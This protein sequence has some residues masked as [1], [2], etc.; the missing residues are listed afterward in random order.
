MPQHTLIIGGAKS[1]KSALALELARKQGGR[2]VF[3][4]TAQAHDQEMARR[5]ARH[6]AERGPEWTTREEPL[7]LE[8]A[9]RE[10]DAPGAV[11]LVD[12]LTL[13]LSNLLTGAGL[14]PEQVAQRGRGLARL[15]PGL[16]ARVILVGNE[17]GLGIV[18]QHPLARSFRDLSGGLHQELARICQR[19]VLCAAG[20]PLVLKGPAL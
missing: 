20:L 18:P 1:G 8:A 19:V 14:E 7:E 5:I 10:T 12:C 11:L 2:L 6:Q 4:A 15:L 16:Q 3:I 17:V 9:L 13:W